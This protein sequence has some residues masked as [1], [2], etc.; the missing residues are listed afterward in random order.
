M[1][2]GSLLM[3]HRKRTEGR[4]KKKGCRYETISVLDSTE[5]SLSTDELVLGNRDTILKYNRIPLS[6]IQQNR[7]CV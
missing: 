2:D 5:H 1:D 4:G 7:V 3:G 6:D